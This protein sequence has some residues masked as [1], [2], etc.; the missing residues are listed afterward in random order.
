MP[1]TVH[2]VN[3][4]YIRDIGKKQMFSKICRRKYAESKL[5]TSG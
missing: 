3:D 4:K 5:M 2:Y 1:Y